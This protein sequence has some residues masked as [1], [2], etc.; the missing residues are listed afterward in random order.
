MISSQS[1]SSCCSP[2]VSTGIHTVSSVK[3]VERSVLAKKLLFKHN[4]INTKTTSVK[5]LTPGQHAEHAGG[6]YCHIPCYAGQ[7]SFMQYSYNHGSN[8]HFLDPSYLAMVRQQSHT[9]TIQPTLHNHD[10]V[11]SLI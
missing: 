10:L 3:S 1:N 2:L 5:V 11:T 8:Q 9:G 4:K 6:P 7:L